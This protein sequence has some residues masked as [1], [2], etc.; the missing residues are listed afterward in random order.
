M[1]LPILTPLEA[2]SFSEKKKKKWDRGGKIT[3][4]YQVLQKVPSL[5]KSKAIFWGALQYLSCKGRV[6]EYPA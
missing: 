1:P 6:L 4:L 2:K 3:W 5:S